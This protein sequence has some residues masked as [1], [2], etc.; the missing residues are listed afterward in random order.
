MEIRNKR[1][2]WPWIAHLTLAHE[3]TMYWPVAKVILLKDIRKG[4]TVNGVFMF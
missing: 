1:A 2:I 4:R 3:D